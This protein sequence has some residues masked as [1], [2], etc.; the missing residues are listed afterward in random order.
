[1]TQDHSAEIP[2]EVKRAE[3]AGAVSPRCCL[4]TVSSLRMV[5]GFYTDDPKLGKRVNGL[6]VTRSLGD[7]ANPPCICK[8]SVTSL[9]TDPP[10]CAVCADR[11]L[12]IGTQPIHS[13]DAFL[14]MASDGVWKVLHSVQDVL[15]AQLILCAGCAGCRRLCQRRRRSATSSRSAASRHRRPPTR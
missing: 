15:A 11:D 12:H 10:A 2:E 5:G 3:E 1:M 6:E 7:L 4:L 13:A 9:V 14:I 8:P